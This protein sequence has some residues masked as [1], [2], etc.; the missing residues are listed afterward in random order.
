MPLLFLVFIFCII[1]IF[2]FCRFVLIVH[3]MNFSTDVNPLLGMTTAVNVPNT[4]QKQH[5]L[6]TPT[7]SGILY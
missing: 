3:V 5:R 6:H 4:N 7:T 2:G 1:K